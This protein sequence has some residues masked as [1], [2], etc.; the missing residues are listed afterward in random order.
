MRRWVRIVA[1]V[2]LAVA[3]LAGV[4]L[5]FPGQPNTP[6]RVKYGRVRE[7]MTAEEVHAIMG[8]PG[9]RLLCL[10]SERVALQGREE[11]PCQAGDLL[12]RLPSEQEQWH[13][14]PVLQPVPG[15]SLFF[16]DAD[17]VERVYVD[18]EDGRVTGK[19]YWRGEYQE[20]SRMQSLLD[21]FAKLF[22]RVWP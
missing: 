3:A 1:R 2:V 19:R 18:F 13:V 16:I 12:P 21:A 4:Q 7:G 9:D 11:W 8:E 20:P 22:R 15:G 5:L 17:S 10:P 14:Y 6:L